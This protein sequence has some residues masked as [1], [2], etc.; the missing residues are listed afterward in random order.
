MV[1][2]FAGYKIVLNIPARNICFAISMCH[3]VSQPNSMTLQ[4]EGVPLT[5]RFRKIGTFES[6]ERAAAS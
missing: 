6:V 5:Q 1:N 3:G 4:R 2:I